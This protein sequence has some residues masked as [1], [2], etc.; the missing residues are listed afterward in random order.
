MS[1]NLSSRNG[2]EKRMDLKSD[3]SRIASGLNGLK[4]G[5]HKLFGKKHDYKNLNDIWNQRFLCSYDEFEYAV[6]GIYNN[7]LETK[8]ETYRKEYNDRRF[9]ELH[10][11]QEELMA[12]HRDIQAQ[13]EKAV[14]TKY[15][16]AVA[17]PL[18]GATAA[19]LLH[20]FL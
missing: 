1:D 5:Y 15:I 2:P 10:M 12:S 16:F 17:G 3:F 19:F 11:K 8:M 13:L 4:S 18:F 6:E 20:N 7:K 9:E 14:R